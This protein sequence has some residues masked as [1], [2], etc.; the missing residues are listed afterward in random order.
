MVVSGCEFTGYGVKFDGD[1]MAAVR[2]I[3]ECLKVNAEACH[4]LAKVFTAG[5]VSINSLL[6]MSSADKDVSALVTHSTFVNKRPAE[7]MR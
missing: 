6:N 5:N 3:A 2:A 7:P 4:T 1:A